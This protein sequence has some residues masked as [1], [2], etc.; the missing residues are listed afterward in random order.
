MANFVIKVSYETLKY[1]CGD[2]KTMKELFM[3]NIVKC[4][5]G[6]EYVG[7]GWHGLRRCPSCN[8]PNNSP[9]MKESMR[10][11][12]KILLIVLPILVILGVVGAIFSAR[13]LNEAF[14]MLQM[15]TSSF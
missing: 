4:E 8:R 10:K 1:V 6:Q 2:I 13:L 15:F 3:D 11:V 14:R 7:G 5:C 9:E 12:K